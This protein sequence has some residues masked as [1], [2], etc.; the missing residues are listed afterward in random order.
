MSDEET[1]KRGPSWKFWA[2]TAF[3]IIGFLLVTM[4][5][6]YVKTEAD[7]KKKHREMIVAAFRM[8]QVYQAQMVAI[9]QKVDLLGLK[10]Y[11]NQYNVLRKVIEKHH[12]VKSQRASAARWSRSLAKSVRDKTNF[13]LTDGVKNGSVKRVK[14]MNIR[15][16]VDDF[17]KEGFK[18]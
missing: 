11:G 18:N 14:R 17:K 3:S 13:S 16:L 10:V 12:K 2:T 4:I 8:M 1:T 5:G 7:S 9:D 15:A 6:Y